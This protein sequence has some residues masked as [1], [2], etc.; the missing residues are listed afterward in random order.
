MKPNQ[1]KIRSNLINIRR[2]LVGVLGYLELYRSGSLKMTK[3]GMIQMERQ[4]VRVIGEIN[5]LL[6]LMSKSEHKKKRK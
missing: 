4:V 5:G 2:P 1:A 3:K 6:E